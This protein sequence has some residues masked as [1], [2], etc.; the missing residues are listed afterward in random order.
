[1]R[2]KWRNTRCFED[3]FKVAWGQAVY[4]EKNARLSSKAARGVSSRTPLARDFSRYSQAEFMGE[5]KVTTKNKIDVVTCWGRIHIFWSAYSELTQP[6]LFHSWQHFLWP[7][8]TIWVAECSAVVSIHPYLAPSTLFQGG[9]YPLL[10]CPSSEKI[11]KVHWN[12]GHALI[13]DC[14]QSP[15]FSWDRLDI[16]R[17]TVTGILIFKCTEGAGGRRLYASS[18]TAPAPAP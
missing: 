12:S 4:F 6:D 15:I 8:G 13:L 14:S 7:A 10:T 16:P 11:Y 5:N 18:Q 17:L 1:M 3:A 9:E 2:W